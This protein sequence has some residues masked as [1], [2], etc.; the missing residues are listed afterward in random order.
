MTMRLASRLAAL[1]LLACSARATDG[2][3]AFEIPTPEGLDRYL[4]APADNRPTLARVALGRRLFFDPLLSADGTV[5]CSSCH[6]PEYVFSDTVAVSRGVYGRR[7]RRNA[8]SIVNAGYGESFFWDGR[9]VGLEDQVLLPIQDPDEMDMPLDA[10][11]RRVGEVPEYREGFA[12]A[13]PD[14]AVSA[15]NLA[16]ALA[17][18]LRTLRSG[19]AP[20]DGFLAGDST[21]LSPEARDGFRLFVGRAGCHRCHAGPTLTDRSFHNTGIA[22]RGGALADSGR[23]VVT[24]APEALGAFK[25]PSLRNVER[26]AP[27]MHDG[28]LATLEEVVEFYS[29]GGI[30]NPHLDPDIRP[31]RLSADERRALLAFLRSFT[32]RATT[33]RLRICPTAGSGRGSSKTGTEKAIQST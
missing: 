21:A 11:L 32:G 22:W 3:G 14:R 1:L 6:H 9:A 24:G 19:D 16:R 18:Y 5:S 28:S 20:L 27:Y 30:P 26:T 12:A 15:P 29:D 31:L 4:P 7:G 2:S 8:P 25:T 13:F 17:G 33:R 10:V 23:A